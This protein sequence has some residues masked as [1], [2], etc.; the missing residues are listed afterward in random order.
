MLTILF[1]W[2]CTSGVYCNWV[3]SG[4]FATEAHCMQAVATLG[5]PN[6]RPSTSPGFRCVVTGRK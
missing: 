1:L 5:M 4:E 3:A 2:H 6:N